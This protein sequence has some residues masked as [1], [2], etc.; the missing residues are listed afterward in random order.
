MR[1][2]SIFSTFL[3]LIATGVAAQQTSLRIDGPGVKVGDTWMYNTLNGWT[4]E[5]DYVS[6]NTV[7][8]IAKDGILMESTPLSG[9]PVSKVRRTRDFNLVSI[10]APGFTQRALPYYP[11][12]AFPLEVGKTWQSEVDLNS[13][14]LPDKRVKARLEG[15]VIGWESV[16]VPAGTFRALKI[17]VTGWYRASSLDGSW[18]GR[19]EDALWYAPEVRNA[20][21]YEYRDTL[22]TAPYS[23]EI[24]ELV[25]YWLAP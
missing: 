12:Y 5:L 7:K 21:R 4:G 2:I 3:L 17:V 10:D 1:I 11:N 24:H 15:K 23:V 9:E 25:R 6:V 22:E 13:T 18:G 8:E 14:K 20:V 19:I 16:T